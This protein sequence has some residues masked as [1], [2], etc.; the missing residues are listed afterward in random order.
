MTGII[1]HRTLTLVM[2]VLLFFGIAPVQTAL[3]QVEAEKGLPAVFADVG[4]DE[5]LGDF[6][7]PD[8]T[9]LN[10]S[11]E[12]V[13]IGEYFDGSR[14]VIL[15]FVYHN[16]PMLCSILLESFTR[17][18]RDMEWTP[19]QEFD[20]LTVSFS[21]TEAP[22]LAA[23]QKARYV[24]TL[25]RPEAA[26]G[27]HFLTGSDE[28]IQALTGSTGFK[29]KWIESS[30]EFAHPAVLIFLSGEGKITRYIHGMQFPPEDVRKALVEAS[31][32]RV[33]STIDR[34][35]LYCYR[36]DANANSYVIHATKLMKLG[37]FLTVLV[38]A[39]GLAILWRRER[40]RQKNEAPVA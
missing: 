25:Q 31:E 28:S 3:A 35:F 16:C 14:P 6:V 10:E 5:K 17:T 2:A 9:F 19:G 12:E 33:G 13:T 1:N 29:F 23:Q 22:D 38:L 7:P 30:Q 24:D 37:G 40:F 34:I 4:V 26:D 11:G 18:L 20:V 39:T 15:N 27:W 21:A 8:L 32:G 36:Y